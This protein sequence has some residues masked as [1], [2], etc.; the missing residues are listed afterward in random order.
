MYNGIQM[1]L[2]NAGMT[3]PRQNEAATK[4]AL[5]R[6]LMSGGASMLDRASKG[7]PGSFGSS[8]A[9]GMMGGM[10]GM[11]QGMKLALM[12][13]ERANALEEQAKAEK[14]KQEQAKA[15]ADYRKQVLATQGAPERR[16]QTGLN[17]LYKSFS[18]NGPMTPEQ[19]KMLAM[20]EI[21]P[22]AASRIMF[23]NAYRTSLLPGM[24]P[25]AA[26]SGQTGSDQGQQAP[27]EPQNPLELSDPDQA[28][29]AQEK[30]NQQ[31]AAA[32][33][34]A[35]AESDALK[36]AIT[37]NYMAARAASLSKSEAKELLDGI[38]KYWAKMPPGYRQQFM[39]ALPILKKKAGNGEG[40]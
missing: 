4:M 26:M 30:I 28:L 20:A 25:M 23:P 24:N 10:Q 29:A 37:K 18:G 19:S 7:G 27:V 32:K 21:N 17:D 16:I 5:Y 14:F 2:G 15:T 40:Q 31:K 9:A 36:F 38:N 35:K 11:D 12:S 39:S 6:A 13:Q 3:D 34:A 33:E 22:N 1:M 8:M